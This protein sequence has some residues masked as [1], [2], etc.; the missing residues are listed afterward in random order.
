MPQG[1]RRGVG[2]QGRM[3]EAVQWQENYR[4]QRDRFRKDFPNQELA[5]CRVVSASR[6]LFSLL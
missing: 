1:A 3:V 5:H 2:G 6:K 4:R